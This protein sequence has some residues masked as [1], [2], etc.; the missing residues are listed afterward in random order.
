MHTIRSFP[1]LTGPG[2]RRLILGSIPGQ[3]SL[4]AGQY[5]AHPRNAFWAIAAALAGFDPA[6]PYPARCEALVGAGFA[7]WD[8]L[9]ACHRPGSLDASIVGA[10]A[11]ANDLRSLLADHPSIELIGFNGGQAEASFRRLVLP[12]LPEAMRGIPRVR[13]PS[14][15]PAHAGLRFED[16]L[17]AWRRAL[18]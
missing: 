2:V 11:R 6:L 13:L 3:R 5:Y 15:S 4:D 16:K 14:T 10:S 17:A 1:P 9:A 7:L 12:G 18:G 8:V